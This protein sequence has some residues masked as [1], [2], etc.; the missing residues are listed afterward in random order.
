MQLPEI[1]GGQSES[2]LLTFV[3]LPRATLKFSFQKDCRRAILKKKH[4][5]TK[6]IGWVLW[7]KPDTDDADEQ[8]EEAV[9]PSGS[10]LL[11]SKLFV[12]GDHLSVPGFSFSSLFFFLE[13]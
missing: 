13:F 3:L 12:V 1:Q 4:S 2:H 5:K 9:S 11:L 8:G 10:A 6:R 7:N